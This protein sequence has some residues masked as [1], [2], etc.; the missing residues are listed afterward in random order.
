MW[1]WKAV[2]FAVNESLVR[3]CRGLGVERGSLSPPREHAFTL[4]QSLGTRPAVT[5]YLASLSLLGVVVM[6]GGCQRVDLQ[7]TPAAY[8]ETGRYLNFT[9]LPERTPDSPAAQAA[10]TPA[11]REAVRTTLINKGYRE[12][13]R[14]DADFLVAYYTSFE[15]LSDLTALGYSPAE[16]ERAH[17]SPFTQPAAPS[18]PDV[19]SRAVQEWAAGYYHEPRGYMEMMVVVDV[20]DPV[21]NELVWRGWIRRPKRPET[22]DAE[23]IVEAVA[24]L[25][26]LFPAREAGGPR[27]IR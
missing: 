20:V 18:G 7:T 1:W 17:P 12:V 11:V 15:V 16:W 2:L 24:T 27:A 23:I 13:P 3:S 4:M 14:A 10:L 9:F 22:I 21:A 6:V 25:L 19:Q 5:P 8:V 26:A